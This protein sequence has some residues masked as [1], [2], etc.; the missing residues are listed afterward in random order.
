MVF[1]IYYCVFSCDSGVSVFVIDLFLSIFI[2]V[3]ILFVWKFCSYDSIVFVVCGL[4]VILIIILGVFC[5]SCCLSG[6]W[7]LV[8]MFWIIVLDGNSLIVFNV[9]NVVYIFWKGI[10]G[11]GKLFSIEC[12]F[13]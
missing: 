12:F 6:N 9:V 10:C 2:M 5:K 11:V 1:V 13:C 4:C 3:C 8:I 7:V